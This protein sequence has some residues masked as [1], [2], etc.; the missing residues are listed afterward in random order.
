MLRGNRVSPGSLLRKISSNDKRKIYIIS[1]CD[2]RIHFALNCG[3]KSCPPIK[4]YNGKKL[5]NEL[6]KA[7]K[8][9]FIFINI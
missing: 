3:A 8:G 5:E 4:F 1:K 6:D 7:A 9:F 2:P